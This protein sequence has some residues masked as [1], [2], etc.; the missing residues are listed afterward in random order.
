[1]IWNI[2][3]LV[4]RHS[5]NDW[6]HPVEL[7][8]RT[9][10]WLVILINNGKLMSKCDVNQMKTTRHQSM[11]S[12]YLFKASL[13][14]GKVFGVVRRSCIGDTKDEQSGRKEFINFYRSGI[15]KRCNSTSSLD[16]R[17]RVEMSDFIY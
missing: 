4:R 11:D 5:N 3:C 8:T 12:I 14:Q 13:R 17:L 15:T 6:R 7:E 16:M 2:F 9:S 1:M 10:G